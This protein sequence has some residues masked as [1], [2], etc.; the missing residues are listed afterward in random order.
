MGRCGARARRRQPRLD[1]VRKFVFYIFVH[2]T[3]EVLPFLIFALA[4]GLMPL[5]LTALQILASDLGTET[6]PA[7]AL[8][9]E[10]AEPGLME[11]APRARGEGVI[12]KAMLGRAWGFLG[13]SSAALVLAAFFAVLLH[14]GRQP[15]D[16]TKSG[17]LLHHAYRQATTMTFLAIGVCQVGT[18]LAACTERVSLRSVGVFSN[19]L[20][21]YGTAFELLFAAAVTYVPPLQAVFGTAAPRMAARSRPS[22]LLVRPEKGDIMQRSL[23]ATDG[24]DSS[25]E[26]VDFGLELAQ[27]EHAEATFVHVTMPIEWAVYPFGPL[28]AIPNEAP[29]IDDDEP[30][31]LAMERA[32]EKGVVAHPVSILGDPV[33]EVAAYAERMQADLI[34]IGSRGLGG[35]TSALLGSVSRGVLKHADRPV[36]V[37][38]AAPAAVHA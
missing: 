35:V 16:A 11:R 21:L 5:P 38:R 28:D 9:R 4:G 30:L 36:L 25:L 27:A 10:A 31:R 12:T 37:V 13:L 29:A 17:S 24:S 19:R 8:G 1:N 22:T 14:A 15:G 18:A 33:L 3:P 2:A 7:L 34:V 6:L 26:A 32:A 20:L 23:I